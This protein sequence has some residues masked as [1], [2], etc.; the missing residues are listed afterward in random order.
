MVIDVLYNL[1]EFVRGLWEWCARQD[2]RVAFGL[3]VLFWMVVGR[4][5]S[6]LGNP[7]QKVMGLVGTVVILLMALAFWVA[8]AGG[9]EPGSI[10]FERATR[11][12]GAD[13]LM[14]IQQ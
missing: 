12:P 3:G 1:P 4:V 9:L 8:F 14:E 10:P 6:V 5:F 11:T 2:S 13:T 7:V